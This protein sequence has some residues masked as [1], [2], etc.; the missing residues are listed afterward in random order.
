[1]MRRP[2]RSTLFP[3]TTLFRSRRRTARLWRAARHDGNARCGPNLWL[4]RVVPLAFHNDCECEMTASSV[5]ASAVAAS[6]HVASPII[7]LDF[8][9]WQVVLFQFSELLAAIV[10]AC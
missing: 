1:M 10:A 6:R 3:Y 7:M 4:L 9:N 2:P 8:I 5:A